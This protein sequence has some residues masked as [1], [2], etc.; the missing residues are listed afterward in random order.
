MMKMEGKGKIEL[1]LKMW[2][3]LESNCVANENEAHEQNNS[4]N[5]SA[6]NRMG[7][8]PKRGRLEVNGSNK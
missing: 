1:S 3:R 2:L 5:A 7:E 6:R 4:Q 8:H